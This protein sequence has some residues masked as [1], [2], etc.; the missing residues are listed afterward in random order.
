[1]DNRPRCNYNIS[2]GLVEMLTAITNL[3]KQEIWSYLADA[4][5]VCFDRMAKKN[6]H[7]SWR[8][9]TF[10]NTEI[11]IEIKVHIGGHFFRYSGNSEEKVKH[12][13]SAEIKFDANQIES[14]TSQQVEEFLVE[15]VL[16]G[17]DDDING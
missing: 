2:L 15:K 17:V 5:Q 1:M 7:K 4:T 11:R 10:P 13:H 9:I 12:P 16:L 3:E 6:I 14:F 8:W